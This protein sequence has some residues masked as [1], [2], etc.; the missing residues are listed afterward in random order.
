M[1]SRFT[2]G[3][4]SIILAFICFT[5]LTIISVYD[6]KTTFTSIYGGIFVVSLTSLVC[7][8][9]VFEMKNK[10]I[11]IEFI[12]NQLKINRYF[13]IG[14]PIFIENNLIDGFYNCIAHNKK[15]TYEY[16]MIIKG[17]KKFAKIACDYYKNY[18]ELKFEIHKKYKH[19]GSKN[20]NDITTEL[21]DSFLIN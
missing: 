3:S 19:L 12:N 14:N 13:G 10:I 4:Y 2:V 17:N 15:G 20:S 21:K 5:I 18:E 6:F 16:I 11:K 9:S 1:K 7:L 8:F